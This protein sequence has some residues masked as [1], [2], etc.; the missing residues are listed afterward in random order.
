MTVLEPGPG[1]GFF[2]LD[3]ARMVG[4]EGRVVA[5][6]VQPRMIEGL[7]RRAQ[8]AGLAERIEGRLVGSEGLGLE[9]LVGK[10]D[11]VLVFAVAH[12]VSD[13]EAFFK[14]LHAAMKPGARMLL[15][16]PRGHVNEAEFDA[17]LEKAMAAGLRVEDHIEIPRSRAVVLKMR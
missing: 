8:R 4:P 3:L 13:I 12:E 9:D 16:E 14:E 10:A 11:F 1:L 15:T 2:T 5:L 17:C 7:R 6:D